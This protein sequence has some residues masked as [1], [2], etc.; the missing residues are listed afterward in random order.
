MW[1]TAYGTTFAPPYSRLFMAELEE[2]VLSEIELKPYPWWRQIDDIFFLGD[3][4][5]RI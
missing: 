4:W 1:G 2:E 3:M 5:K